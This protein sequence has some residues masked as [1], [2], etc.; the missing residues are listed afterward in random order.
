MNSQVLHYVINHLFLPPQLPQ[1]DDS[2]DIDSQAALLLH[3]SESAT[4]FAEGLSNTD[5]GTSVT[6]CWQI[7]QKMLQ[8]M[9]R[10]HEN[11]HMSLAELQ[12]TV[13]N[14]EVQGESTSIGATHFT[15]LQHDNPRCAVSTHLRAEHRSHSSQI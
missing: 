2:G 11:T 6:P 12:R 9:H 5:V 4:A 10:I 1:E 14:M 8:S 7:L 13:E 15:Y 3:I